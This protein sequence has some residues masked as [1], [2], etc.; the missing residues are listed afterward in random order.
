MIRFGTIFVFLINDVLGHFTPAD[1]WPLSFSV[2]TSFQIFAEAY[3]KE[4][5]FMYMCT[6][7]DGTVVLMEWVPTSFVLFRRRYIILCCWVQESLREHSF[8]NVVSP[9][10]FGQHWYVG[11][12]WSFQ[13]LVWQ[14]WFIYTRWI[15]FYPW[16]LFFY[17]Q[18][19][20]RKLGRFQPCLIVILSILVSINY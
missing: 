18:L 3:L 9:F 8:I 16:S 4:K 17:Y 15:K 6:D 12:N 7:Q 14:E 1:S 19:L 10:N 13:R 11:S 20:Y 2:L 5:T